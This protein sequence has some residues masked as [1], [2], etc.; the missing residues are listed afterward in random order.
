MTDLRGAGAL[1][2]FASSGVFKRGIAY[3][4]EL[5]GMGGGSSIIIYSI[6]LVTH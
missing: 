1:G 4:V 6:L 2:R 3:M 5:G